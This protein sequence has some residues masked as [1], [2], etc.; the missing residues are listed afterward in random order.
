MRIWSKLIHA[1]E[2]LLVAGPAVA[3]TVAAFWLAF[4][5]VE[6]APPRQFAIATASKG[7]P[8][9][10]FAEQYR[11]ILARDG[12]RLLVRESDGSFDNLKMLKDAGVAAAFLQGG[13]AGSA[14]APELVS[15]G[16]VF[17]EPVW[18]FY[19]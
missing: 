15:L 1:R 17:Y 9:H 12:V 11:D 4:Q 14:E 18:I 19:R 2:W 10:R 16:R 6:P 8:Y 5:F 13:I 3:L 7:S